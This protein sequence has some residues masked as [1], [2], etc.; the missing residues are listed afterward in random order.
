M[1]MYAIKKL[2]LSRFVISR[3]NY[4]EFQ[5]YFLGEFFRKKCFL[6]F[7]TKRNSP[8]T[9]EVFSLRTC[10]KHSFVVALFCTQ[11]PDTDQI[12]QI[13]SLFFFSFFLFLFFFALQTVIERTEDIAAVAKPKGKKLMELPLEA[14][15]DNKTLHKGKL[16]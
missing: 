8:Y 10:A 7:Q 14:P 4:P 16:N 13:P 9:E 12:A 5:F 3:D 1:K 2:I 15:S 11:F 6:V